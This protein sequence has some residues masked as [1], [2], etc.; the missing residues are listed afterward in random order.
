MGGC[1]CGGGGGPRAASSGR[2]QP[3]LSAQEPSDARGDVTRAP[4]AV[5]ISGLAARDPLVR[6]CSVKGNE[7]TFY[8]AHDNNMGSPR[9]SG[10]PTLAH[11]TSSKSRGRTAARPVQL[12]HAPSGKERAQPVATREHGDPAHEAIKDHP[13]PFGCFSFKKVDNDRILEEA[14]LE[15]AREPGEVLPNPGASMET[16]AAHYTRD[17]ATENDGFTHCWSDCHGSEF[18]V[19]SERYMKTKVKEPS[20][21]GVYVLEHADFFHTPCKQYHMSQRF[22]MPAGGGPN[23]VDGFPKWVV[24]HVQFPFYNPPFF[25]TGAD[26]VGASLVFWFRLPDGFDPA[27]HPNQKAMHL[28]RQFFQDEKDPDGKPVRDRLKLIPKLVNIDEFC[29]SANIS[30]T[31]TK[32]IKSYNGKP[33]LTRPQHAFHFDP[34][35]GLMDVELNVHEWAFLA[36]KVFHGFMERFA[37]AVFDMGFVV[38]GNSTEELPEVVLCG[39]RGY[40]M[41]ILAEAPPPPVDPDDDKGSAKGNG[42]VEQ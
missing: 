39:V 42:P 40:R 16:V 10:T 15:H 23:M 34:S 32:L 11:L 5:H 37:S 33:I 18:N 12:S 28:M 31:E 8:D 38:Q 1:C 25:S 3:H 26:G 20:E 41:R 27:A 6:R 24:L 13:P 14:L 17:K 36:R 19:R 4:E 29:A 35:K 7:E 21:G 9:D 30:K 22:N 2:S